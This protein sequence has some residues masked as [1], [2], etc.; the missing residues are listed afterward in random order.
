MIDAHGT[1]A[2]TTERAPYGRHSVSALG[3]VPSGA[4]P[5]T[6]YGQPAVKKS[7]YG[8]LIATY[9]FVGGIAGAT[10]LIAQLADLLGGDR[11]RSVVRA[12]RYLALVGALT[13][14][15]L[16]VKDLHAP[17]RWYNMLRIFRSTSPMSIGSWTLAAFGIFSGLA[18]AAQLLEDVFSAACGRRL[19]R[20]FGMPAAAAGALMSFYTGA[21]LAATSTPLWAVAYRQL[22]P[23]F[24]ASAVATA[25]AMLSLVLEMA[26]AS[27]RTHA[28]LER[29]G[30]VASGAQLACASATDAVWRRAGVAGPLERQPTAT[31]Y[32]LVVLALGMIA[33]GLIHV[34]QVL[35][36]RRSA[37]LS[38]LAALA[39]LAGGV[40][41]RAV[42]VRAG[43]E[44]A[45]RPGDY[46]RIT[47]P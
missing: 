12:G 31:I 30:L 15:V 3:E 45:Q 17:S 27:R 14:P 25:T 24:G 42:V 22:P 44:S 39:T 34:I 5:P 41:E 2:I 18:A 38:V 7:H 19:G 13:S 6:Y 21:L 40:A 36:G 46:F 8:W 26:G 10:Q 43:S 47:Q 4:P 28:R 9:L 32:R 33:P 23:L 29:I 37:R 1:N 11:D 35:S 16:L 20:I